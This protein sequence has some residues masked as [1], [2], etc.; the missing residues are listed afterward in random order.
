MQA[1]R[2]PVH[3][4]SLP[5]DL[6]NAANAN[7]RRREYFASFDAAKTALLVID[8]QNHW[9]HPEGGSY[10]PTAKGIVPNINRLATKLRASG[11]PV[12][13]ITASL[14]ERG[15]GAWPMLFERLDDPAAGRKERLELIPGHPMHE[16]WPELDVRSQ[17]LVVPKDR[18]SAFARDASNLHAV[19][20]ERG[21][22]TV[23]VT[24]V[25]TNICC[26][27]TARDAMMLDFRTV[28]VED[29]NAAHTDEDHL[30]GLRTF[31]QVFGAVMRTSD[32]LGRIA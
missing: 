28:M 4:V 10:V 18:F 30:A 9:V 1:P 8:M 15:R 17:D 20:Q 14:A 22:D 21:V 27:S 6:V 24:G 19:L 16:L 31:I 13:W 25:T 11:G 2:P 32:V 7:A 26:E 5:D 3:D 29:A 23:I 12:I